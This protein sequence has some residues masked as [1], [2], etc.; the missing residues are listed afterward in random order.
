ME[1]ISPRIQIYTTSQEAWDA[2]YAAV[3]E[4]HTSIYWEIYTFIDDEAGKRFVDILIKKAQA[5]VQTK[6]IVDAM[7]SFSLSSAAIKEMKQAGVDVILFLH[8][9]QN[10]YEHD[11]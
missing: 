3:R 5:G 9:S 7:G 1:H 6:L 10:I 2:M 8:N 11:G 4:A